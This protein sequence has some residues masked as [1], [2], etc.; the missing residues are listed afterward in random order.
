MSE[1]IQALYIRDTETRTKPKPHTIYKVEVNAAVRHWTVWKR[2]SDFVSLHQQLQQLYPGQQPPVALPSKSY[3]PST[4]NDAAKIED[5]RQG[6]EQYVRGILS[7][8]DDRWRQTQVWREFLAVPTGRPTDVGYT[9]ETWLDEYQAMTQSARDTRSLINKRATHV[10]RNEVSAAHNCTMQAKKLIFTLASRLTALEH[11]LHALATQSPALSDGEW[12]RRQ[13]LLSSL[14]E[15]KDTLL[16]LVNTGRQESDLFDTTPSSS[17]SSSAAKNSSSR[18]QPMTMVPEK[19]SVAAL[20]KQ[21]LLQ[22]PSTGSRAFGAAAASKI[23]ETEAT[24]SLDN[25]GLLQYQQQMM[26]DQDQQV[27]QFSAILSRQKQLGYAIHHELDTQNQILDELDRDA[28]RTQTKLKFANKKL[29][30][31]N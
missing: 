30:N 13:D 28:T 22:R 23:K 24:R 10:A 8:R 16:Q 29:A 1:V 6:L 19:Q 18:E 20:Q 25:E 5:R 2:Y 9:S 26:N 17:S 11:A 3:F 21:Q 14:K 12:R 27:E 4:F 7:S 15:E 31:I